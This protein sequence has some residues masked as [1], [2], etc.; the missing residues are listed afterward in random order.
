MPDGELPK[1]EAIKRT[2]RHYLRLILS[3]QAPISN[4]PRAMSNDIPA[5]VCVRN[6]NISVRVTAP[7]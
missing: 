3:I 4:I 5:A 1:Q 6:T 2:V 7:A